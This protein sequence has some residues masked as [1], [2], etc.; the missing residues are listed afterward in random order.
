[1]K[2]KGG[3][4]HYLSNTWIY[5]ITTKTRNIFTCKYLFSESQKCFSPQKKEQNNEG[6]GSCYFY[7][8]ETRKDK[9]ETF[10][11]QKFH[12]IFNNW[13]KQIRTI[14]P[15]SLLP[16]K[17]TKSF[18]NRWKNLEQKR[19]I[20]CSFSWNEDNAQDPKTSHYPEGVTPCAMISTQ[21]FFFF[22]LNILVR[23]SK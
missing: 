11:R 17:S 9:E 16:F 4:L 13:L 5:F 15:T 12:D 10:W 7:I 3:V 19:G 20:N 23:H 14:K 18:H 6:S 1:M 2:K 8:Q 21:V 22:L